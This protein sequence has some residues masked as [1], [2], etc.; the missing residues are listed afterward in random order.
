M[1]TDWFI[2]VIRVRANAIVAKGDKSCRA[3]KLFTE[4]R[5]KMLRKPRVVYGQRAYLTGM[6]LENGDF[7]ILMSREYVRNMVQVYAKR[8]QVETLFGAFKSRGFNLEK[9]RVNHHHRIRTLLFLLA[10]IMGG[11]KTRSG[12]LLGA[13]II[14]M[15]PKLLDDLELFR[16]VS[17]VLASAPEAARPSVSWPSMPTVVATKKASA[18]AA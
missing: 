18:V 17:V 8:W 10:I 4:K 16:I 2:P 13:A 1:W 5:L 7:L 14:V 3:D 9:C 11:R 12:A 15:L 6:R